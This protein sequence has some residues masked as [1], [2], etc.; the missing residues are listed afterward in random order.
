M[1]IWL[2]LK[3]GFLYLFIEFIKGNFTDTDVNELMTECR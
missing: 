3:L 1:M 2:E